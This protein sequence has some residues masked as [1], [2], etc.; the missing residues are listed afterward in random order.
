MKTSIFL[1]EIIG[2]PTFFENV[3]VFY[4]MNDQRLSSNTS[5]EK[6][7]RLWIAGRECWGVDSLGSKRI[8]P[9]QCFC[10][11]N[12]INIIHFSICLTSSG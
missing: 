12:I 2:V 4:S 11:V 5:E 9:P 7:R 10:L 1:G 3:D 6:Q 8:Q